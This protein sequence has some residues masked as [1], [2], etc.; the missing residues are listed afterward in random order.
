MA[1][2]INDFVTPEVKQSGFFLQCRSCRWESVTPESG[3][4]AS[5]S[6]R[7]HLVVFTRIP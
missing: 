6:R 3:L 2:Q 1:L 7:G 4:P 5:A